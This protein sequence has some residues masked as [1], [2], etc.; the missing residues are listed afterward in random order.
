MAKFSTRLISII[1]TI[2]NKVIVLVLAVLVGL[3]AVE[4]SLWAV[5]V[6]FSHEALEYNKDP[7]KPGFFRWA[8]TSKNKYDPICYFLPKGGFFRGPSGRSDRPLKK[9][10]HTI[11]IMCIGDSVTYSLAV[12]YYHSWVYL[13]GTMLSKKYP[14][15]KIEVLNAGIV[16]CVPKQIK[17]V[18]QFYLAKYRSDILIWRGSTNLTDTYFVDTKPDFARDFLGPF[19]YQSRT[20][21]LFCVIA[22]SFK[23]VD[24]M[25][26]ADKI[27]NFVTGRAPKELKPS[28]V[29]FDS[30]FDMVRKIAQDHG[31]KYVLQAEYLSRMSDGRI[32][33]HTINNGNEFFVKM[34]D[35]FEENDTKS[36]PPVNKRRVNLKTKLP[37]A[38]FVDSCH[39]TERGEAITAEKIYEFIV[40]NKWIEALN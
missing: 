23:K 15:K 9:E 8:L 26:M 13:L 35:A 39:L 7:E 5:G 27:Y 24:D 37:D 11:R 33:S 1:K 2:R 12:D 17:R 14:E 20:F 38:L 28:V 25:A 31:T 34:K 18:F 21:R 16:G 36:P 6:V 10:E 22:D 19:L 40:E 30:D 4:V 3:V 29:G 32:K